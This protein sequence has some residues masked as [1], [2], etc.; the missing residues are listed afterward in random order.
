[1]VSLFVL[2]AG[3]LAGWGVNIVADAAPER[4][5][6][7]VVWTRTLALL[8]GVDGTNAGQRHWVALL[9][10]TVLAAIAYRRL[11][12]GPEWLVASLVS[13]FFLAVAIIDIEHRR[14]LNRMLVV[15]AP[16]LLLSS[17][18]PWA[19]SPLSALAGALVGFGLFLVIA[20]AAPG[21]MGMG[22][23]KLAG[24]IGLATGL[25]GTLVALAIGIFAGGLA[26]LVVLVRSRFRRGQTMAYA[27]YLVLGAWL[28]IFF[29]Q[30][31]LRL[32]LGHAL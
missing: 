31:L 6:I 12:M 23:V 28:A 32:Y 30:D 1:M 15:A 24:V 2:M 18:L 27:P 17:L 4:L 11:G 7:R 22:D 21:A 13:W 3:L 14:V 29:G 5:P 25:T 20:L 10:A 26:A 9:G 19:P 8:P 16:L